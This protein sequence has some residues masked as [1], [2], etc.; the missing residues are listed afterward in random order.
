MLAMNKKTKNIRIRNKRLK[1]L[2]AQENGNKFSMNHRYFLTKMKIYK[3]FFN[4]IGKVLILFSSYF[5]LFYNTCESDSFTQAIF[6][7]S[8]LSRVIEFPQIFAYCLYATV[9]FSSIEPDHDGSKNI[10]SLDLLAL[11]TMTIISYHR[12]LFVETSLFFFLSSL[13]YQYLGTRIDSLYPQ[14]RILA[15]WATLQYQPLQKDVTKIH[16]KINLYFKICLEYCLLHFWYQNQRFLCSPS[17]QKSITP[18]LSTGSFFF[19][20]SNVMVLRAL[21][22]DLPRICNEESVS[23]LS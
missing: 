3:S 13:A 18:L 21:S 2:V 7:L 17:G 8:L 4:G 6:T 19:I 20:A 14:I 23:S 15:S 16:L 1:P 9:I 22:K 12:P 5:I 10:I 11:P